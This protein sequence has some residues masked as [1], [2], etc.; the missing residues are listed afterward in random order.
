M[1]ACWASAR[2]IPRARGRPKVGWDSRVVSW[3]TG[4]IRRSGKWPAAREEERTVVQARVLA[5][6]P[7]GLRV[8]RW[9]KSE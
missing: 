8:P 6:K 7:V 5:V 4:R 2:A 1:P 9:E 3:D